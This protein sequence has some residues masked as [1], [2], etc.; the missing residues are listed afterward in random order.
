MSEHEL[1]VQL[2]HAL[3]VLL[4]ELHPLPLELAHV[5]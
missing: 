4:D 1:Q 2:L 5:L 3:L